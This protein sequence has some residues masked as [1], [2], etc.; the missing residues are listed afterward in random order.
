MDRVRQAERKVPKA[1]ASDFFMW[2]PVRV[3]ELLSDDGYCSNGAHVEDISAKEEEVLKSLREK[4]SLVGEE[5]RLFCLYQKNTTLEFKLK[6]AKAL[7][8]AKVKHEEGAAAALTDEDEC[9]EEKFAG[10]EFAPLPDSDWDDDFDDYD[11]N[12]SDNKAVEKIDEWQPATNIWES[13]A[14]KN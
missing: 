1:V 2:D 5:L 12:G 9:K 10:A 14:P 3:D 11:D 13:H 6:L 4:I 8:A 7:K